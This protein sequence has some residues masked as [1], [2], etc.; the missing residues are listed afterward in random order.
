MGP[1]RF[2]AGA[3]SGAPA[4]TDE[5]FEPVDSVP[6]IPIT[7]PLPPKANGTSGG[8]GPWDGS[9]NHAAVVSSSSSS[10]AGGAGTVI[11]PDEHPVGAANVIPL[12]S[13]TSVDPIKAWEPTDPGA[14]SW[15]PSDVIKPKPEPA[16]ESP[17]IAPT[18]APVSAPVSLPVPVPTSGSS[19]TGSWASLLKP[20]PPPPPQPVA[21]PAPVVVVPQPTAVQLSP[22]PQS[23]P[24]SS[25]A[26][27]I[28][29]PM[30]SKGPAD[31][32]QIA[33][34]DSAA[35]KVAGPGAN[36]TLSA[37]DKAVA[38]PAKGSS[39]GAPR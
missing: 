28:M 19:A 12:L 38:P 17:S 27:P 4:G 18:L 23:M 7:A 29:A 26:S 10:S 1:A 6:P 32:M 22:K 25:A 21:P 33:P 5:V 20:K 14:L 24:P 8:G 31:V 9:R 36:L 30:D 16:S 34:L 39:R 35:D 37:T 3:G 15:V 11:A 13:P 2:A